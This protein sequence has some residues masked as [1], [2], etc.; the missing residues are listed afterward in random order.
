MDVI[1]MHQ[2]VTKHD[3][4]GNDIEAMFRLLKMKHSCY[5]YAMTKLNPNVSYI[6]KDELETIIKREDCIVIYHHS[7]YWEDG[8]KILNKVK[9]KIIFRYHNIT[10]SHF[11]EKYNKHHF[12]Q[13]ELGR[14]QTEKFI[15]EYPQAYWLSDSHFNEEDLKSVPDHRKGVCPPFHKIEQ[16]AK[17]T[18]DEDV[19]KKLI[20]SDEINLLF[21]GRVV[22]NKGH[23][24]LF[25]ILRIFCINYK[26]NI[27]LRI[28]G[29]FDE[30]LAGYNKLIQETLNNYG[31]AGIVEFVGEITD[32]T[33]MSYYLGS[34]I[35]VCTSEH[36]G[37]C[38]PVVEAQYF[39][40]PVLALRA[41]AVPETIG[42]DQIIL[43]KEPQK[44]VAAIHT[45]FEHPEYQNFLREKA[46]ENYN[47]RFAEKIIQQE[48][49][50]EFEK[51]VK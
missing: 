49:W 37:F 3:A 4:I 43:D 10:P 51:G 30:G 19:L 2:T 1:I 11:F 40:L 24:M 32:S 8:E 14:K 22:P 33:L 5:V 25:D 28:I 46:L 29:K 15:K 16:W 42:K 38:V 35:M 27:R 9:G 48:F 20:T 12:N 18:P 50:R 6:E 17:K 23:M 41:C 44:Y 47:A 36:E 45:L 7:V 21:V 26:T 34:D 39:G 13:C 31:V